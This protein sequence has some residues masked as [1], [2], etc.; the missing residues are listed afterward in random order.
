MDAAQKILGD[1]YF[2]G[3]ESPNYGDFGFFHICDITLV[4]QPS[5]LDPYPQLLAWMQ[6]IHEIPGV[7]KYI[8]ARPGPETSGWGIPGTVI[9]SKSA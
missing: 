3:G 7:K 1:K 9:M 8:S 2:F 5:A 6:R 4:V